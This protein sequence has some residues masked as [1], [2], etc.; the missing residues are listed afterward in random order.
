MILASFVG[1]LFSVE[2]QMY[3][4]RMDGASWRAG[5]SKYKSKIPSWSARSSKDALQVSGSSKWR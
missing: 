2:L 3:I 5:L 1:V 4:T